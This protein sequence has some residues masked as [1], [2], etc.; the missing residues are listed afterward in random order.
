MAATRYR[1]RVRTV[2][3]SERVWES[4]SGGQVW[5]NVVVLSASCV[6]AM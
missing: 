3:P 2:T 1:E 4:G 6:R 5:E